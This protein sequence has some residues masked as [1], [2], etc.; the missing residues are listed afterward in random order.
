MQRQWSLTSEISEERH[1]IWN[2]QYSINNLWIL[3]SGI[4]ES[5]VINNKPEIINESFDLM[6]L[7]IMISWA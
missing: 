1:S 6:E 7:I 3:L 4:K 2:I 5:D